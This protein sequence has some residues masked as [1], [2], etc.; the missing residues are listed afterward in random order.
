MAAG[1]ASLEVFEE[2]QL[3]QR[4]NDLS[5]YFQECLHSGIKG[6][7]NV[8]DTR[9]I[10]MM[11]AVEFAP[12][13]GHKRPF[14]VYDRCFEKGVFARA[15]GPQVVLSPSLVSTKQDIDR[16]IDT[17]RESIKESAAAF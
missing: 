14:D 9:S 4:A 5:P 1:I 2:Q 3:F 6:L 17:L 8:I 16:I 7:P 12:S 13:A 11:G 10:G 15:A